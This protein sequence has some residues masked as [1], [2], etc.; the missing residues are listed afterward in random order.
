MSYAVEQPSVLQDS[1]SLAGLGDYEVP[2]KGIV[3]QS[4]AGI[5]ILQ[6]GRFKY[7]NETFARMCGLRRD[8]LI[9]A[10]LCDVSNPEQTSALMQRYEQQ[11]QG[12]T[13]RDH[14]VIRRS[15]RHHPGSFEIHGTRVVFHGRPAIVG[16]GIDI[17]ERERQRQQLFA[18]T[19]RLQ[20]LVI[21]ANT[22]R[23]N[24]RNR[25]ARELH[26]VIGGM[27][28]AIKFDL[29][30]LV[31][32][33]ERLEQTCAKATSDIQPL[34]TNAKEL[35]QITQDTVEAVRAISEGLRPGALDHLGLEDTLAQSVESFE[36][37]YGI[38]ANFKRKGEPPAL[39]EPSLEVGVY[40]IVQEALT[41]VAR[42]S[43]AT[44][45]TVDLTWKS[46]SLLLRIADDGLGFPNVPPNHQ[47][48][49]GLLGM[50]E[51]A[52]ELGG[53]VQFGVGPKSG[54]SIRVRIPIV[55]KATD[56]E[57]TP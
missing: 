27:L 19:A 1:D 47:G 9:N 36:C 45:V 12:D 55:N 35:I 21:N 39:L 22:V 43:K 54:A 13:L 29:S 30:R 34:L 37:R 42:H 16:V 23:E 32:G 50:Q 38:V 14:F 3:E 25:V 8:Q 40:R 4:I 33:M 51:R 2:F 48:H 7:V 46:N 56:E 41:N 52:R 15:S 6:E 31:W 18:V 5:Y 20:E 57:N 28:T 44:E 26:D 17:T 49:L 11:I 53:N 24:E 10:K